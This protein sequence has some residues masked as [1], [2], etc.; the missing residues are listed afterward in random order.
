MH[1]WILCI[2]LSF[3]VGL[4]APSDLLG[5]EDSSTRPSVRHLGQDN[6]RNKFSVGRVVREQRRR[7]GGV[8]V[9]K[10][11]RVTRQCVLPAQKGK[12]KLSWIKDSV[13]SMSSRVRGLILLSSAVVRPPWQHCVQLSRTWICWRQAG[14][15]G[16]AQPAEEKAPS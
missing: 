9:D 12:H 15:A 4:G 7:T 11:L 16:T 2:F 13:G 8:L 3:G 1:H 5:C 10:K 14:R 6:P